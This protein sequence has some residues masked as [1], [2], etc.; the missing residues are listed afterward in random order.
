M[1]RALAGFRVTVVVLLTLLL[2]LRTPTGVW[3]A[4]RALGNHTLR[5]LLGNVLPVPA[6]EP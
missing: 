1:P 2:L 6:V 3:A 5:A 4:E